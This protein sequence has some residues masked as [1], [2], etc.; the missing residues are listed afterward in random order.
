MCEICSKL[1]IKTLERRQWRR[2][3]IFIVKP[4]TYF[5]S[6][7]NVSIVDFEQV[8]I[9]WELKQPL[10]NLVLLSYLSKL[11]RFY[12]DKIIYIYLRKVQVNFR[13]SRPEVFCKKGVLRNLAKFTGKHLCWSFFLIKLQVWCLAT[14]LIKR[15]WQKVFSCE[16]CKISKITFF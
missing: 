10:F 11:I 12:S 13:S 1:T 4:W 15:L 5:T 6:F 7:F 8:N 9:S 2:S 3:G 14:L 16:F